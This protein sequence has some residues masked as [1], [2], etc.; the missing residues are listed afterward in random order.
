MMTKYIN[1]LPKILSQ[2]MKYCVVVHYSEI[3]LKG[4]N[5]KKFEHQLRKNISRVI[6]TCGGG[7]V[8]LDFGRILIMLPKQFNWPLLEKSLKNIFGIA[9]FA[10]AILT[11]QN[12]NKIIKAVNI[13]LK[14]CV[15]QS[16]KIYTKRAQKNYPLSS[17]QLNEKLGEYICTHFNK[18]VNLKDPEVICYIEIYNKNS[19]IFIEKISGLGGLPVGINERAIVLLSSGIDSPVA[20]WKVMRRGVEIIFVH[21]HSFPKT[22]EASIEKAKKIVQRLTEYQY[23]SQLVLIPLLP[24]QQRIVEYAPVEYRIIL[25]R[26]IMMHIAEIVA[27]KTKAKALVTGESIGQVASQTLGNIQVIDEATAFPV[28]RPLIG[29]DK[30]DIINLAQQIGTYKISLEPYEDC[31]SLFVPRHPEIEADLN[32]IKIIE[33][34]LYP[35]KA[36]PEIKKGMQIVKFRW[37]SSAINELKYIDT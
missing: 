19:L 14:G 27:K 22:S 36:Y 34:D 32:D 20:A 29:E 8:R 25:Y 3:G 28:L 15:F 23:K 30:V 21:F 1:D 26:R 6:E 2:D 12:L 35:E 9:N 16:F 4:K 11:N 10:F 13:L 7:Q 33:K 5:R 18:K 31:C 17:P 37:Q 24:A